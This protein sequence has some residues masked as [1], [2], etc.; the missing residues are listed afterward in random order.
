MDVLSFLYGPC[1]AQLARILIVEL[2]TCVP[3]TGC[4]CSQFSGLISGFKGVIVLVV[5]DVVVD[6]DS[7]NKIEP[8]WN[9]EE[10]L[11]LCEAYFLLT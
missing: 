6:S 1:I 3:S 7:K 4:G 8:V 2:C 11:I 10:S 9:I 5:D